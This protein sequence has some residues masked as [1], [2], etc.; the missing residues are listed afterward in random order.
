MQFVT[1]GGAWLLGCLAAGL[2]VCLVSCRLEVL[3]CFA[4]G[5]PNCWATWLL[6]WWCVGFVVC[7]VAGLLGVLIAWCLGGLA[8]GLLDCLIAGCWAAEF[9]G[10]RHAWLLVL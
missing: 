2:L 8:A 9:V 7:R 1:A 5:V 10:W 3:G 6:G 4:G